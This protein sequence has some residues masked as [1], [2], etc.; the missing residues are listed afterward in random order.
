M[1][2]LMLSG[3]M[4]GKKDKEA[5]KE[6]TEELDVLMDAFDSLLKRVDKIAKKVGVGA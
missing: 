3:Q 4:G 1:M 5:S 2:L 6:V